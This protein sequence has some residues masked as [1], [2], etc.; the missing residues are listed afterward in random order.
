MLVLGLAPEVAARLYGATAGNP[1]ALLELAPDA[2]DLALDSHSPRK[3]PP[4]WSR[5][6]SPGPSCAGRARSATPPGRRWS[7]PRRSD[8]CDLPTLGRAAAHLGVDLSAL[9]AAE[10]AGLVTLDGGPG[11]V[12]PSAGP[13]G[14]LR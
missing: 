5:P 3:A 2:Q 9:A 11:G 8:R 13:L 6:R 14:H 7:W 10:A 1:L 12:P 4:S